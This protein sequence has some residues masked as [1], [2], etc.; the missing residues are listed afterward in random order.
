MKKI[1]KFILWSI[2]GIITL[3]VILIIVI[4]IWFVVTYPSYHQK[5]LE[6]HAEWVKNTPQEVK[7]SLLSKEEVEKATGIRFPPFKVIDMCLPSPLV[8]DPCV[9]WE[10]ELLEEFETEYWLTCKVPCLSYPKIL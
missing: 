4:F 7:N 3:P 6:Q 10:L 2:T 8:Q 1:Y 9:Y 5:E